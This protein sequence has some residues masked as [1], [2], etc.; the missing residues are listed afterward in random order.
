[1]I[2]KSYVALLALGLSVL[3]TGCGVVGS[4]TNPGIMWAVGESAPMGVVVRRAEV[5]SATADQIDRLIAEMPLDQ[6]AEE[7]SYLSSDDAKARLTAI[8]GEAVYQGTQGVRVVPAEAWLD[9]LASIC[10]TGE[11]KT[12]IQYLGEDTAADYKK[13]A[14]TNREIAA[15]EMKI[16]L[17]ENEKDKPGADVAAH[18]KAIADFEAQ[19]DQKEEA[20]N[21]L[22]EALVTKVKAKAAA[23]SAEDRNVVAPFI[24]NL[25]AALGDARTAAQAANVRYP[26]AATGMSDDVKK[27]AARFAAD[28]VEDQIGVRPDLTGLSPD[29]TLDGTDVKL[30]LNNVPA[31]KI[32]DIKVDQLVADTTT[33]TT[34]YFGRALGLIGFNEETLSRLKVQNE[35]LDAWVEGLAAGG[36]P[37]GKISKISDLEVLA[38]PAAPKGEAKA[39]AAKA[40]RTAGGLKVTECGAAPATPADDAAKPEDKTAEG[41]AP[42][43][44]KP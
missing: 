3:G 20:F 36:P 18:E 39:G 16:K 14:E 37:S 1:M 6:A 28:S 33:K 44:A 38:A 31:E 26:L 43:D 13:V 24:Y 19:I 23:L 42:A 9:K 4:L 25:S 35:I 29:V 27:S 22:L 5:A 34:V 12:A 17:E 8:G 2:G 21:P 10:P 11:G 32:G 7:A 40:K 15:L 41:A 30:T